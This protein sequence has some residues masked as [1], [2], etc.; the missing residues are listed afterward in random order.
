MR[1]ILVLSNAVLEQWLE[2]NWNISKQWDTSKYLVI[3]F[4]RSPLNRLDRQL[5][6]SIFCPKMGPKVCKTPCPFLIFSSILLPMRPST[7]ECLRQLV[8]KIELQKLKT[9]DPRD[10]NGVQG[11]ENERKL[12]KNL[13]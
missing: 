6:T 11:W 1:I 5:D 3:R 4:H 8:T 13:P 12:Y 7:T 10:D 2:N 9:S